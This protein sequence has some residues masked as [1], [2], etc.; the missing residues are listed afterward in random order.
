MIGLMMLKRRKTE[1]ILLEV[2]QVHSELVAG[3]YGAFG[4]CGF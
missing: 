2:E 4:I 3:I 1:D